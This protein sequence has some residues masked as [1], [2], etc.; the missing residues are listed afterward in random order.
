MEI[1]EETP[2]LKSKVAKLNFNKKIGELTGKRI[3]ITAQLGHQQLEVNAPQKRK[4]KVKRIERP[5]QFKRK[6]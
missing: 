3:A 2:E 4:I 5:S 1:I 6:F